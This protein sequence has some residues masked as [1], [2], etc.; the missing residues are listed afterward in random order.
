LKTFIV[1][2]RKKQSKTTSVLTLWQT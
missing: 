1:S 2:I